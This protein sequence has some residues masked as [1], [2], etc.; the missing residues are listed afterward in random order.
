MQKKYYEKFHLHRKNNNYKIAYFNIWNMVQ[1][2]Q[3]GY[4]G[5]ESEKLNFDNFFDKNGSN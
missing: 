3:H 2:G 5:N 1:N 4:H